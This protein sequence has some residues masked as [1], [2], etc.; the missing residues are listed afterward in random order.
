MIPSANTDSRSRAPPE[1]MSTRPSSVPLAAAKM[2][3]SAL[4]STPGTGT[5]TPIR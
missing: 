1:N 5:C 2:E 3:A 4:L